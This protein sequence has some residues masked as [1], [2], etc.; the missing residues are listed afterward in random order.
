MFTVQPDVVD[1]AAVGPRRRRLQLQRLVY[2]VNN[3]LYLLNVNIS[4]ELQKELLRK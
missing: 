2:I 4:G 3:L 1:V